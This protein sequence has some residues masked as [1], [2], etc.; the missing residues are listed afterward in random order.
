MSGH[1]LQVDFDRDGFVYKVVCEEG[2]DA[3][4]HQYVVGD[5]DL[6]ED[7]EGGLVALQPETKP[8]GAC[9]IAEDL[10]SD[11]GLLPELA[12]GQVKEFPLARFPIKYYANTWEDGSEWAKVGPVELVP[13]QEPS[14][15]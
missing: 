6:E 2:D 8:Y 15:G 14:D 10:N 4:C 7:G 12:T 1:W 11:P 13:A 5:W 9:L 3:P